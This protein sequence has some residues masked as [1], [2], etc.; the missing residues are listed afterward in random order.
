MTSEPAAL[1]VPG[2]AAAAGAGRRR[3]LLG[4]VS[5]GLALAGLPGCG[6][7]LWFDDLRLRAVNATLDI[8]SIDLRFN[9]WLSARAIGYGA[10]TSAYADGDLWSSS[11]S[12]R[13]DVARTGQSGALLSTTLA[14]PEGPSTSVVVMASLGAGL[15][16]RLID[17]GAARPGGQ[18]MRLRALHAWPGVGALDVFVTSPG[19][20]LSGRVPDAV[21]ATF[22]TLSA[23]ANLAPA[24][25]LRI[26]PRGQPGVVLFDNAA[27]GFVADQVVTLVVAPA[28]SA[29]R[30]AVAVLPQ[31]AAAYVLINAASAPV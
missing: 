6:G 22:E 10:G 17:E 30:V 15:K 28:P 24:T 3:V 16:L 20:T 9:D 2:V 21:L 31:A 4:G 13:F 11:A 8:A 7:G 27:S 12:G 14:L 5:A 1:E 26:M 29:V 18:A 25:R 19:Q 23:F